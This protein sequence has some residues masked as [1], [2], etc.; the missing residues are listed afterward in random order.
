M[1]AKQRIMGACGCG[2]EEKRKEVAKE[3]AKKPWFKGTP[4]DIKKAKEAGAVVVSGPCAKTAKPVDCETK[5]KDGDGLWFRGDPAKL[6]AACVEAPKE[7]DATEAA[8]LEKANPA[9]VVPAPEVAADA[10]AAEDAAKKPEDAAKKPEAAAPAAE[11]PAPAAVEP[12][13]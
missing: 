12:T 13:Q 5:V 2:E 1:G 6:K 9:P 8:E 11:E 3:A 7:A 10:A 4:A